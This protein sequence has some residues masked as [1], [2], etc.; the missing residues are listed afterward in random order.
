MCFMSSR[1]R[2]SL[3][4]PDNLQDTL[5]RLAMRR[6]A[7]RP[8]AVAALVV[9]VFFIIVAVFAP[10]I[11]PDDPVKTSWSLIRKAPSWAIPYSI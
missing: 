6:F 10:L 3:A 9:V 2:S 11:A 4:S 5:A 1:E 8:A 7:S